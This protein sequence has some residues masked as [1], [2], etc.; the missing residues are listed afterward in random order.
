MKQ[1]YEFK[2]DMPCEGCSNSAK[3]VL[4]KIQGKSGKI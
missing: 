3:K 2:F 1:V 4:A